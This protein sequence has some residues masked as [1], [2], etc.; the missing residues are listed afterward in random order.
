MKRDHWLIR[1]FG[2]KATIF[3]GDPSVADRWEWL[4]DHLEKGPK[5][6]KIPHRLVWL[7]TLPLRVLRKMDRPLTRWLGYPC[8]SIA[9]VGIKRADVSRTPS[10]TAAG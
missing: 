8:L 7:M 5:D 3:H 6:R 1:L 2:W 9:V 4:R 10:K